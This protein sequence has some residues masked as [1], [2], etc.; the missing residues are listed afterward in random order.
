MRF[1][2]TGMSQVPFK[3]TENGIEAFD[4]AN[5]QYQA[6]ARRQFRQFGR[7]RGVVGNWFLDQRVLP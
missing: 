3:R 4:V 2:E 6:I 5:L 1:D 7:V